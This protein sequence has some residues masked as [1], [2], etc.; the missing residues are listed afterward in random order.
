MGT[1]SN[2]VVAYILNTVSGLRWEGYGFNKN[3]MKIP[4]LHER[5]NPLNLADQFGLKS[6]FW[7]FNS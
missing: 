3:I 2:E 6:Q 1:S 5:P 4:A 7:L